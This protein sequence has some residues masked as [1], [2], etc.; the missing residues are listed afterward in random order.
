MREM[1]RIDPEDEWPPRSEVTKHQNRSDDV[2]QLGQLPCILPQTSVSG[3]PQ[4]DG[5]HG[6]VPALFFLGGG[7]RA[8]VGHFLVFSSHGCQLPPSSLMD[9]TK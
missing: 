1:H 6:A 5:F 3:E 4:A 8:G 7:R 2:S 9:G